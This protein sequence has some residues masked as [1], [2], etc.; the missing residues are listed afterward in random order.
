MA[1]GGE[2]NQSSGTATMSNVT[3]VEGVYN[4]R[5]GVVTASTTTCGG[6]SGGT[7][8]QYGV[9]NSIS[10]SLGVGEYL[11]FDG[12]GT[13]TING[14]TL[15]TP[16][17]G[18]G[19]GGGGT[20]GSFNQSGG[21]VNAGELGV[22]SENQGTSGS[23]KLTNGV[24]ACGN[25]EFLNG[26]FYQYGGFHTVTNTLTLFG[27][28]DPYGNG[29]HF[30]FYG[31]YGGNLVASSLDVESFS[32]VSQTGGTNTVGTMTLYEGM[33]YLAGGE[34]ATVNT[35]LVEI[36]FGST[37]Y[38]FQG[39]GMHATSLLSID[40]AA[41]YVLSGGTL[42]ASNVQ[43]HGTLTVSNNLSPSVLNN[44]GSFDL[45]GVLQISS[46]TQ[47]LGAAILSGNAQIQFGSGPVLLGFNASAQ[48]NWNPAAILSVTNWSGSTN[49]NGLD[50]LTFGTNAAALTLA[51]LRQIVFVNP[52][53]FAPAQYLAKILSSGEVVPAPNPPLFWQLANGQLIITWFGQPTLQS[54]TNVG[55]PYIDVS[56]ASSPY[57]NNLGQFPRQFFRLRQ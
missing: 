3:V 22:G 41:L 39:N 13:Y 57:T 28:A 53:G 23:Y 12:S 1:L 44:P 50:Q 17:L 24:L 6:I 29:D 10:V 18:V 14:G 21:T 9:T 26:P 37:P 52:S 35:A 48:A 27:Y 36:G 55:G 49:G 34:L 45:A 15:Q 30:P 56:G 7:F 5:N 11:G 25:E 16:S 54:A 42:T 32:E 4:L 19:A 31:L 51:Q 43:L 8:N 33:Y 46:T 47:H 2:I 38:F 20:S 40:N